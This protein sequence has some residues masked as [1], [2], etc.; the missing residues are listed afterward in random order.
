MILS[1]NDVSYQMLLTTVDLPKVSQCKLYLGF[2]IGAR[3]TLYKS[4]QSF[5]SRCSVDLA[6]AHAA[7]PRSLHHIIT[8]K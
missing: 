3:S 7:Q 1:A 5:Q 2:L 4:N 6:K 8:S